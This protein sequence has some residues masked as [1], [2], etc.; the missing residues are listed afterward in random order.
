MGKG[1]ASHENGV[2]SKTGVWAFSQAQYQI[3]TGLM[4]CTL[5]IGV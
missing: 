2:R 1:G 3:A 4:G 5:E